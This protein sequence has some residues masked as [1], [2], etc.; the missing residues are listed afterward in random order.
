[1][2]NIL[3]SIPYKSQEDSDAKMYPGDCGAA[4]V[5]MILE[6]LGEQVSTNDIFKST[7]VAANKYLGRSDLIRAARIYGVELQKFGSW[8][9]TNIKQSID[10]GHPLI[11][12]VNYGAWSAAGSGVDTQSSFAGPHFVVIVGYDGDKVIFQD[13]LWWGSRRAEGEHRALTY[14]QFEAA[15]STAHTYPG[16]P[17]YSGLYCVNQLEVSEPAKSDNELPVPTSETICRIKAWAAYHYKYISSLP[18]NLEHPAVANAY[19]VAMGDWGTNWVEHTV[20]A[21]EDLGLIAL[22][23]YGDPLKWKVITLFND[24]P[25]VD[26]FK[27]GNTLKIPEPDRTT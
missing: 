18:F 20:V 15:W 5:A 4:C 27:V 22:Q 1:M 9:F 19:L 26:A 23:Y 24:M 13:P 2:V 12:L 8:N 25:P 6:G 10:D 21:G 3:E 17:D 7:G 14:T 11:A 16:N